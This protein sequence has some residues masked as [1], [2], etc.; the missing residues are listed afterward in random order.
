MIHAEKLR[1]ARG[2]RHESRHGTLAAACAALSIGI[3]LA[4]CDDNRDQSKSGTTDQVQNTRPATPPDAATPGAP[5]P[6]RAE[7]AQPPNTAPGARP[8]VSRIVGTWAV[9]EAKGGPADSAAKGDKVEGTTYRFQDG[10]NV[11]VAGAKQCTYTLQSA[12]LEVKCGGTAIAGPSEFH[13]KDQTIVWTVGKDETVTL[14]K[15]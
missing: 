2:P 7:P 6:P 12:A 9:T 10:G 14:K 13:D 1:K 8:S 4:A 3:V 5:S 11:T 15:R